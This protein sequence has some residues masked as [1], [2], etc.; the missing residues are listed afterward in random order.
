MTAAAA[1]TVAR[2]RCCPSAIGVV[3]LGTQLAASCARPPLPEIESACNFAGLT[4]VSG[5]VCFTNPPA[6]NPDGEWTWPASNP[7]TERL[8][9]GGIII[10]AKQAVRLVSSV[11]RSNGSVTVTTKPV[12]LTDVIVNGDI[13]LRSRVRL[14]SAHQLAWQ[15]VLA[16]PS[17]SPSPSSSSRAR[18]ANWP[19]VRPAET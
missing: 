5:Y 4:L 9:E 12:P 15:P 3:L 10:V 18:S 13:P 11:T 17:P 6:T 1:K 7:K 19:A 8:K 14:D 2:L 16:S